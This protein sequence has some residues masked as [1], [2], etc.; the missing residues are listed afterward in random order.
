MSYSSD[1]K[2]EIMGS[3]PK[4]L[5][6]R[7]AELAGFIAI[8]GRL[9]EDDFG[10]YLAIRVE[11][12]DFDDRI[13][14]LVR[15][16]SDIPD[17]NIQKVDVKSH[18]RKLII[19]NE[20]DIENLTGRLKLRSFGTRVGIDDII[21]QRGCC[22]TSYLKGAFLAGGV[23]GSPEKAYQLEINTPREEEADKLIKLLAGLDVK[24]GK[25]H[26]RGR[27]SVYVKEGDSIANLI[28]SLGATNGLMEFENVRI[29]K[30]IRNSINREVNCD[31]ANIAKTAG[32]AAK[33]LEDIRFI[34]DK[35]G[36]GSLPEELRIVAQGRVDNPDL[37]LK[38]LG[39]S[40]VPPLGK[41]G[42]NHRMRRISK[43]AEEL[44]G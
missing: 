44:R 10:K 13:R 3:F 30:D 41:S 23:I 21:T 6:C 26:S 36:L 24:A 27:Y 39:E 12:S 31:T 2:L 20:D 15:I 29:L 22:R 25:N 8:N 38:E 16:I 18:H 19:R 5:H 1:V 14:R 4:S 43:I 34:S 40:L 37:T 35:V 42:V 28:G 9:E 11:N 7:I 33:Q 32:A 17:E